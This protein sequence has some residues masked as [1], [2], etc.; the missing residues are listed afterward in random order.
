M[1]VD[2]HLHSTASDG[3]D[4]PADVVRLGAAA[5]LSTIALTDHD[6]LDGIA[7]ARAAAE[8]HGIGLIPGTELSVVWPDGTMHLLV[9]H[10][11]PGPGPLQEKLASLRTGRSVRNAAILARLTELG[12]PVSATAVAEEAGGGVVGRPHIAA[13]LVADGHV[14]TIA[15]AF[16]RYLARGRPAYIERV[17][18]EAVAAIELA[19]ASGAVPVLA[20]PHTIGVATAE[21]ET[22]FRHL[23]AAG[24]AGIEAFYSEY[25][26]AL[27][28]HLAAVCDRLGLVATGGSD[29][30]GRYKPDI[31]VGVGRGDL[32][33]PDD[34]VER[35]AAA[36]SG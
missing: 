7:E 25:P 36:R 2:L 8:R 3:T 34:V 13:V 22:A 11:E 14:A 20:H 16:D 27:R 17:R 24:L 32:S 5:G 9:Y 19:R 12:V 21:Y 10:L 30:H 18:L 33:V 4:A 26:V 29:Y 1:A 23:A 35:I 28:E 6:T 15:A 31:H